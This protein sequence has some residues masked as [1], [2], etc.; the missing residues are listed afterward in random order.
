MLTNT[1]A[2]AADGNF[3]DEHG[4]AIKPA[5]VA[6]YNM[7]MGQLIHQSSDLEMDDS[8]E[9]HPFVLPLCATSW[10]MM[11]CIAPAP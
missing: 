9:F 3:C 5:I 6:D 10:N 7:H 4:S 8:E 2:P 11:E 1:Q